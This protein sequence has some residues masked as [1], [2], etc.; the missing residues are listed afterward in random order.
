MKRLV[1]ALALSLAVLPSARALRPFDGTD[2]AVARQGALEFEFG[3][4]DLLRE[5]GEKAMLA[6]A[7]V[8]NAGIAPG[9]ELVLEGRLR[10]RFAGTADGARTTLRDAAISWKHVWRDG[11]LQEAP[12]ASVA[13]ECGALLPTAP[14]ERTGLACTGVVSRRLAGATLHV[15]AALA[16]TRERAWERSLGLI[17]E[18]PSQGP[19]R[20]VAE[21]QAGAGT[22]S[23]LAGLIFAVADK[24]D[25]DIAVRAA[26]SG[27]TSV[28]ELRAG[29]TW[30][31][32]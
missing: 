7:L 9:S 18:G 23:A 24:L 31:P 17:V 5:G 27:A 14:R 2:A 30:S 6:P 28:A 26:R 19:L 4:L 15:N 16:R 21:L 10:T 1:L 20:P 13:S 3:Y 25:V 22:R 11:V 8:L 32:Q 12:G 29:L